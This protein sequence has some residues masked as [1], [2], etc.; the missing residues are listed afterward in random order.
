MRV[1]RDERKLSFTLTDVGGMFKIS[2]V[3]NVSVNAYG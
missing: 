2:N 1:C 3:I